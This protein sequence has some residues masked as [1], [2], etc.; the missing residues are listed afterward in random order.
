MCMY[1]PARFSTVASAQVM[2][3]PDSVVHGWM[4]TQVNIL[5][6]TF[7]PVTTMDLYTGGYEE[8]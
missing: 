7:L 5:Q 3:V 6:S 1:Y 8:K 4:E 2:I